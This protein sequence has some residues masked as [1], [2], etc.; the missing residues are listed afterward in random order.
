MSGD[1]IPCEGVDLSS[2][3][4]IG[5]G[6]VLASVTSE[7]VVVG[8]D[9]CV[10]MS[11]YGVWMCED[12]YVSDCTEVTVCGRGGVPCPALASLWLDVDRDGVCGWAIDYSDGS[13]G[14]GADVHSRGVLVTA[15]E[16]VVYSEVWGSVCVCTCVDCPMICVDVV[17]FGFDDAVVGVVI[18]LVGGVITVFG[19]MCL[20]VIADC[21]VGSSDHSKPPS[22]YVAGSHV[23]M[24][25]S[26]GGLRMMA[27]S[28]VA[29][30]P[31]A[32]GDVSPGDDASVLCPCYLGTSMA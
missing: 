10:V 7:V 11:S 32:G 20:V 31:H 5:I 28:S 9:M 29:A 19:L 13:A 3:A 8:G 25:P 26:V 6:S 30:V 17:V 24:V 12:S 1:P 18:V 21:E 22:P 2:P 23:T 16:A 4:I 14:V 15:D 27:G